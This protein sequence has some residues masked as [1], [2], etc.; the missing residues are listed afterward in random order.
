MVKGLTSDDAERKLKET[1][2]NIIPDRKKK[3]IIV[4][5]FEQFNNFLVLLLLGAGVV[6]FYLGHRVDAVLIFTIVGLNAFFGLYQEQKAE[7]SLELLKKLSTTKTRVIRDGKEQEIESTM[8]VPGDIVVV[9][10]GAKIPADAVILRTKHFELNESV[11]TGESMP[12]AKTVGEKVFMGTLVA[13]GR[14]YLKVEE[15]GIE[16][17][18]GKITVQLKEI[19]QVKSPLQKKLTTL[20]RIIGLVG[21]GLSLGVFGLGTY[22]GLSQYQA[23]LLAVSLAVAVVP[24]GLP[25]VMTMTLA[26]GVREMSKKNAIVRKLPSIETLGNVTLVATDKTGTL[27]SNRMEVNKI[28][29]DRKIYEAQD[30]PKDDPF[31]QNLLVNGALCSTAS[32]VQ[33]HDPS[34]SLRASHSAFDVLGDPTE[35]AVLLIAQKAGFDIKKIRSEW[36]TIDESAFDAK[37]KRMAVKVKKDGKIITFIKGSPESILE[38]TPSAP[39]KEIEELVD[40]WTGKGYRVLAFAMKEENE[41]GK[42]EFDKKFTF[43]GIVAIHD[44]LRPEVAEAIQQASAMGI[45]VVMI[46]GDNEKTAEVIGTEA[47]LIKE[48]DEIMIGSQIANYSDEEL[49]RLLP[50]V[51]IFARTTPLDKDRIVS[52]YQKLGHIVAVTGDGVNDAIALR[53]ADVGIAMGRVGTDVARE[54]A[55]IVLSDDNFASIINAVLEGRSIVKK[56]KNAVAYLFSTNFGEVLALTVGLASGIPE[57]LTAI[58]LLFINLVGDG[59]PALALAFSPKQDKVLEISREKIQIIDPYDRTFIIIV[60]ATSATLVLT[61]YFVFRSF[62]SSAA[63]AAAFATL[64]MIQSFVFIDLWVSHGSIRKNLKTFLNPVF[65]IAFLIPIIFTAVIVSSPA[66]SKIFETSTLSP[67]AFV[68]V[69]GLSAL[70]L[71]GVKLVKIISLSRSKNI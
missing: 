23:F 69:I 2:L 3:L 20:S 57:I 47:G 10:D 48:G 7:E 65:L 9:E 15:T 18:F 37:T 31:Y 4:K 45:Q 53:R 19:A 27:T 8:L 24:E 42:I 43:V 25:A 52:L 49:L 38:L 1:G 16:T 70:V 22:V 29:T 14:A 60:G 17:Q 11:L 68:R 35:G 50:K 46:T 34:T 40:Q 13:R 6:S 67:D 59:M 61:S 21:I 62:S 44:P 71:L 55:D 51:K 12:V 32:L 64:A 28:F 56:L 33:I 66:L 5:F 39:A 36:E 41:K 30:A 63:Q 58:Q 54:T 26:I